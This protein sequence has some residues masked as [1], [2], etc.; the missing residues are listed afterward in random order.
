MWHALVVELTQTPRADAFLA[1]HRWAAVGLLALVAGALFAVAAGWVW[2]V[3]IA[4]IYGVSYGM[5]FARSHRS[6]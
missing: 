2:G 1:R 5:T 6:S 4:L 3:V